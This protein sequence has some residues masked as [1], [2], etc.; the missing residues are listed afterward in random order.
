[1]LVAV[2]CNQ[3]VQKHIFREPDG[4]DGLKAQSPQS[5]SM[6][7]VC[8]DCWELANRKQNN[9]AFILWR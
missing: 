2:V 1:M 3:L 9:D 8:P 5:A 6:Q 4:E 7:T